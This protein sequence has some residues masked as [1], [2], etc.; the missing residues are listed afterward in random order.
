MHSQ[1]HHTN[2]EFYDILIQN[3]CFK[4]EI[5]FGELEISNPYK[6]NP[7]PKIRILKSKANLNQTFNRHTAGTP[8]PTAENSY[9][10]A[11]GKKGVKSNTN[12]VLTKQEGDKPNE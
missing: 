10:T 5:E 8:L 7:M 12:Q 11:G 6:Q 1:M 2:S 9:R 4:Q 3:I